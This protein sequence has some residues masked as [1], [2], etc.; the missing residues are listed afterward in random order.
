M[1]TMEQSSV[2]AKATRRTLRPALMAGLAGAGLGLAI[3]VLI[4]GE[5]R[6]PVN[7]PFFSTASYQ[8]FALAAGGLIGMLV[9]ALACL[10]FLGLAR[11]RGYGGLFSL[12]AGMGAGAGAAIGLAT[13]LAVYLAAPAFSMTRIGLAA[14]LVDSL[15]FSFGEALI[16][17][18]L[19]SVAM[20]TWGRRLSSWG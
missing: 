12:A 18:G 9:G 6:P 8:D 13:C 7:T 11:R 14:F 5:Q 16:G 2:L 15:G 10:L 19:S 17:L 4:A 3:G 1:E 20:E